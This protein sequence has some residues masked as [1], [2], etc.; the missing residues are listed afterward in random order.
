MLIVVE[1]PEPEPTPVARSSQPAT[2]HRP[3]PSTDLLPFDG[4]HAPAPGPAPHRALALV[5]FEYR[6]A[7]LDRSYDASRWGAMAFVRAV[8]R[9]R[10]D[11][12]PI[13]TRQALAASFSRESIH[14]ARDG[15]TVDPDPMADQMS[16]PV[17]IAYAIRWLELGD[18]IARSPWTGPDT[19]SD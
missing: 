7:I 6:R 13:R 4:S 11:L 9:A 5:A 12:L 19:D 17:E 2:T 14:Q 15:S 18:G 1:E 10:A 8:G 3:D 16:G